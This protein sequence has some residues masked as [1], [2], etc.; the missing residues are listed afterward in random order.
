MHE[1]SISSEIVKTVLENVERNE[2]KKVLSL[3]LE[4][5]ELSLLNVEQVVS[6]VKELFKGTVAERAEV[7]VKK[8]KATIQCKACGYKGGVN[9]EEK[10]VFQHLAFYHCPECGSFEIAVKKGRE[11][12][13]RKIQAVR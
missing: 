2:G 13:L 9:P 6:W 10:D 11:C 12:L 8:I 4:I 5:G 7:R 1:F 3:Q